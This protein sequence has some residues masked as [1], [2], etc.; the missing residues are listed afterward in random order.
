MASKIIAILA[1]KYGFDADDALA[2]YNEH[3]SETGSTT[4]MTTVQRAENAIGKTQAKIDELKAK[5]PEKKGKLLDKANDNLK[6]LEEKLA[7]QTKKLEE[8]KEKEAKPKKEKAPSTPKKE[9]KA[10]DPPGAPKKPEEEKRVK[11][12]SPA[13]TKQLTKSFEEVGREFKKEDGQA[14]A[15]YVNEMDP[16]D[17]DAKNLADHMREFTAKKTVEAPKEPVVDIDE[18]LV[19]VTFNGKVY[20]V[21]EI[22]KRV[23]IPDEDNGDKFDGFLGMGKFKEMKMPA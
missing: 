15:K 3:K 17:F 23:Y 5:I 2:F 12:M 4:S 8:K 7:E 22:S 9:K 1:S 10:A 21:G 18:D 13:L 6:K 19:N 14:F 11:R 20:L 16:D